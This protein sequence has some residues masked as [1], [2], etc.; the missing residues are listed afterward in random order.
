MLRPPH[1]ICLPCRFV[2][3]RDGDT[4]E[5]SVYSGLV[6]AIRLL[7]CCCPE[8]HEPGGP[9]AKAFA[10]QVLEE[11]DA[12]LSVWIPAPRETTNLLKNLTFDRVPGDIYVGT[13]RTL[14]SMLLGKKLARRWKESKRR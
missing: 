5:V 12:E 11:A 10:E 8:L 1:G 13:E 9:E 2:R 6:W 14:T 3:V 4:V 7:D